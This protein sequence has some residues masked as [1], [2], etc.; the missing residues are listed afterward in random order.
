MLDY[1][2]VEHKHKFDQVM[3]D[4]AKDILKQ[5]TW[6][7]NGGIRYIGDPESALSGIDLSVPSEERSQALRQEINYVIHYAIIRQT[8]VIINSMDNVVA[9]VVKSVLAGERDQDIGPVI[10]SHAGE[11]KFYTRPLHVPQINAPEGTKAESILHALQDRND[12]PTYYKEPPTVIPEGYICQLHY[13]PPP[14][15]DSNHTAIGKNKP[16]DQELLA[17]Q[18]QYATGPVS[19]NQASQSLGIGTGSL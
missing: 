8:E 18:S 16:A 6:T 4:L 11:K 9:R 14:E 13:R 7:R 15:G 2:T 1:L 10:N 17:W 3:A 19:H 5:Y 12:R